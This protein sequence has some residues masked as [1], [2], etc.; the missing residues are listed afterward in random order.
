MHFL[1]HASMDVFRQ[2]KNPACG[3]RSPSKAFLNT[4]ELSLACTLNVL[5]SKG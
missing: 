1:E 5:P 4:I 2:Q 3:R